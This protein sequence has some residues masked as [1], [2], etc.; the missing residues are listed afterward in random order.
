VPRRFEQNHRK[1]LTMHIHYMYETPPVQ[2]VT[3]TDEELF[4]QVHKNQSFY[5]Y[6]KV[7]AIVENDT[8]IALLMLHVGLV[9][10]K[11]SPEREQQ[12]KQCLQ[13]HC[14]HVPFQRIR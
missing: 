10:H 4:I 13:T 11:G 14:G 3:F 8:S 1:S 9:I 5:P 2:V 7:T 6:S 12:L